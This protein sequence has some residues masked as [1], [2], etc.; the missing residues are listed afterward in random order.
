[1]IVDFLSFPFDYLVRERYEICNKSH[2]KSDKDPDNFDDF[3]IPSHFAKFTEH[4]IISFAE[5]FLPSMFHSVVD[6]GNSDV[7][8][9]DEIDKGISCNCKHNYPSFSNIGW[10]L[11]HRY[12]M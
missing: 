1:M 3:P 2:G 12:S 9:D 11:F 7:G 5:I 10:L 6:D 4:D 8:N